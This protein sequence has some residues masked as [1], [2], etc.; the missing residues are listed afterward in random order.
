LIVPAPL[1]QYADKVAK[2][3]PWKMARPSPAMILAWSGF[4]TLS[5]F[6]YSLCSDGDFSFL[7]TYAA[8]CRSFGFF[9][10]NFRMFMSKS[11]AT[12][13]EI[14]RRHERRGGRRAGRG[15]AEEAA[16]GATHRPRRS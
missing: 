3:I 16:S 15:E 1:P 7:L 5:L 10:L 11:G 2:S 12:D 8:C 14:Q 13:G 6:V 4:F 9:L